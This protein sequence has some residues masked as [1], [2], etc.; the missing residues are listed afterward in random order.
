MKKKI[1]NPILKIKPYCNTCGASLEKGYVVPALLDPSA[2]IISTIC[3][4]CWDI[5]RQKDFD[6]LKSSIFGEINPNLRKCRNFEE[7][8][9]LQKRIKKNGKRKK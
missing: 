1:K 5:A 9:K 7:L 4:E 3:I 2:K 6:F 8:G